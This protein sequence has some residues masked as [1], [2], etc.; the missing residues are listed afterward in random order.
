MDEF[1][2]L[3][4]ITFERSSCLLNF[5]LTGKEETEPSFLR[6]GKKKRRFRELQVRHME[7]KHKVT[8]GN[9]HVFTKGKSCLTNLVAFCDAF[10]ESVDKRKATDIIYLDL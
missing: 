5:P 3:L 4:S 10:A 7:N 6:R 1:V 2:R 8:G 9:Q